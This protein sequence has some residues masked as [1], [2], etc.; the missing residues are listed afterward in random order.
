METKIML[1]LCVVLGFVLGE[2][3]ARQRSRVPDCA[4][5]C[6][7][8]HMQQEWNTGLTPACVCGDSQFT[9]IVY[10]REP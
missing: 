4:R 2:T 8:L 3:Y 5:I 7:E 10:R 1:F 6:L 9:T